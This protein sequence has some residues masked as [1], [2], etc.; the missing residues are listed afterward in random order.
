MRRGDVRWSNPMDRLIRLRLC[1]L[2]C[3]CANEQTKRNDGSEFSPEKNQHVGSDAKWWR[4]RQRIAHRRQR[5]NHGAE[6]T[7]Q[8]NLDST[9]AEK[10]KASYNQRTKHHHE[11]CAIYCKTKERDRPCTLD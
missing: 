9:N 10:D 2:A 3:P 11:H 4:A 5:K 6:R 8:C 7:N 1:A